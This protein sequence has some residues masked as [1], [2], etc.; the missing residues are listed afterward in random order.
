MEEMLHQ[1]KDYPIKVLYIPGSQVV[2][3][4]FK[5]NYNIVWVPI[6]Q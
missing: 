1:L 6:S 4:F 2:Q 3:D 5:A